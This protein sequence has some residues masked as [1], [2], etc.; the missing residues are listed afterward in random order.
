M[1]TPVECVG[2]I[3]GDGSVDSSYLGILISLWNTS[4]KRNPEADINR[5][6]TVNAADIGLL[7]GAWGPCP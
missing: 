3:T 1:V 7:I 4:A 5:D 2:E 6:G